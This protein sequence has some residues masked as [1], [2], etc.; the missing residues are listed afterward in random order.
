MGNLVDHAR[1]SAQKFGGIETDYYRIHEFMDCSKLFLADWRHRALLHTTFG[2]YLAE[3]W[4]FGHTYKRESDGVEVPTR[5]L[6]EQHILE[7][8]R[9]I[10][11]PAE[12]L[13]EMPLRPWMNGLTT[14]QRERL[15][16]LT[17]EDD[18]A[19]KN[20]TEE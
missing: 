12:F 20:A 3:K 6:V 18:E 9:A 17:I 13:R 14:R 8:L 11:T 1:S 19:Q 10:L 4:V 7:D 16:A 15:R 2:M 5:L